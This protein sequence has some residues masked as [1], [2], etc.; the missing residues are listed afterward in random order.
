MREIMLQSRRDWNFMLNI[1]IIRK[2]IT[3]VFWR[4]VFDFLLF[5]W[6]SIVEVTSIRLG[7]KN[8]LGPCSG[9]FKVS[10]VVFSRFVSPSFWRSISLHQEQLMQWCK[11]RRFIL[12]CRERWLDPPW[13]FWWIS[14]GAR[15]WPRHLF[16]ISWFWQGTAAWKDKKK[17]LW[18]GLERSKY[19]LDQ[20]FVK[21]HDWVLGACMEA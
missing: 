18:H 19:F 20:S 9:E 6:Y 16:Q 8:I 3:L 11:G 15:L 12:T 5:F 17:A 7:T 13:R 4:P 1:F 14:T 21:T 2:Q 10:H